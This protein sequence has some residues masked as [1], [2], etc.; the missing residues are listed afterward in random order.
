MLKVLLTF[1]L[2]FTFSSASE[3]GLNGGGCVL[4]QKGEVQLNYNGKTFKNT[5]YTPNALSGK[6]FREIFVNSQLEVQSEKISMKI[7]D[8]KPNKR[9]KGKPKTGIFVIETKIDRVIQT[10]HMDYIFDNG[11]MLVNGTIN[12]KPI[13]FKTDVSYDLCSVEIK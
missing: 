4:A 10:L 11:V 3:M 1:F 13:S 6:N 2:L 5:K 8:Y 12:N 9:M 7:I